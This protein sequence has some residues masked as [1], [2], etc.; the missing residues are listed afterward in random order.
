MQSKDIRNIL[1]IDA[2]ASK[3][4]AVIFNNSGETLSIVEKGFGANISMNSEESIKRIL[5]TISD[6][7]EDAKF[8]YDDIFHY[9]LGVAG[10]SDK[11]ARDLLFKRLEE[12]QI[13]AI[14][15][16]SSDVNPVFEMNCSDNS[17]ILASVGTGCICIG[18]DSENKICKTAGVGLEK[19]PGSGFWMGKELVVNLSFSRNVDQDEVEFNQLLDMALNHFNATELNIAIDEIMESDDRH[20]EIASL[21]GPLIKLAEEGNEIALSIVQQSSQHIS[22]TILLLVDQIEYPSDE[23]TIITNGSIMNNTFYMSSLAD[24][25]KFDFKKIKWLTPTISTAYYPGLLSC[26]MLGLD[27]GIKDII[28]KSPSA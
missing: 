7:L 12:N 19:D 6:I 3:I 16:L 28:A 26:K 8:G 25:I 15:H 4:R 9:S 24:A 27:V 22:E 17:A 23:I 11:D 5:K 18:R 14:T 21:S 20:R 1:S 10:I 2:G 13:A